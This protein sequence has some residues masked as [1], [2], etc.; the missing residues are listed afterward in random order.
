MMVNDSDMPAPPYGE[1]AQIAL[2]F[3]GHVLEAREYNDARGNPRVGLCIEPDGVVAGAEHL[4][5]ASIS[6]ARDIKE[7]GLLCGDYVEVRAWII[8]WASE[9]LADVVY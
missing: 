9:G 4:Q 6:K 7:R 3:R 8:D 5:K 2:R 1:R